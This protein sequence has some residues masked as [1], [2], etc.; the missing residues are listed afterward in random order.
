LAGKKVSAAPGTA[1]ERYLVGLLQQEGLTDKIPISN[2]QT[3]DAAS[4]LRAD[5]IDAFVATGAMAATFEADGYPIVDKASQHTGLYTTNVDVASQDLLDAHPGFSKA[6]GD[7]LTE[8]AAAAKADPD[9]YYSFNATAD[10][11]DV[12]IAKVATPLLSVPDGPFSPDGVQQ[13]QG[14]YD[15]LNK[16]GSIKKTYDLNSWL[17]QG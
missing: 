12:A 9:G 2:L 10:K 4:A 1:P 16:Q 17:D 3:N 13:L 5:Q 6:W 7:A 14:A 15:F 11:V 8:A